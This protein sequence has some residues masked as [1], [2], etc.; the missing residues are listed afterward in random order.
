MTVNVAM[1]VR[2]SVVMVTIMQPVR[3][4]GQFIR[5]QHP[6]TICIQPVK[7]LRQIGRKFVRCDAATAVFV[8]ACKARR[9]L[10]QHFFTGQHAVP[11]GVE[12]LGMKPLMVR[13]LAKMT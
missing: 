6:V 10:C 13:A 4:P 8:Q 5:C 12:F 3:P 7:H 1:F 9:I 2:V 11:V